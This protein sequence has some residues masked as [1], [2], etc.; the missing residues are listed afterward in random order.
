MTQR[1]PAD[2]YSDQRPPV[3]L[4]QIE[5]LQ[6]ALQHKMLEH[7]DTSEAE[8]HREMVEILENG[9][10]LEYEK[11]FTPLSELLREDC[12]LVFHI[13]D[14]FRSVKASVA[15]LEPDEL[16]SLGDLVEHD[17]RY[18]GFDFNDSREGRLGSY[19]RHLQDTHRWTELAEDMADADGGNSHSPM[20]DGYGRMLK[21]Y[22][23]L[24]TEKTSGVS[25][26]RNRY[27][28]SVRELRQLAEARWPSRG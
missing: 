15:K 10:T 5:R 6:L 21:V 14:M 24:W 28:F 3:S 26:G 17:L 8:Y 27:L 2:D 23:P 22:R 25:G 18:L 19:V 4:T 12:L 9:Y 13:L 11:L 1:E 7:L 16:A 20:L